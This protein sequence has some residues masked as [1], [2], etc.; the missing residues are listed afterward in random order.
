MVVVTASEWR[1]LLIASCAILLLASLP[2]LYAWSLADADHVFTGFVIGV[3]DGNSYLAKMRLGARGEW[4]FRL[5]YTPEEHKG[6]LL[7]TLYVLLG[8]VATFFRLPLVL[9]Y[10]LA[11]LLFGLFLLV[12]AYRLLAY[13]SR[14]VS[15]RRLAWLLIAI[16]S[17]LGWLLAILGASH[18]FG[19]L[20]L[21]FW[22]PEAYVFLVVYHLPHVALAEALL[23]LSIL[24]TL[25]TLEGRGVRWCVGGSLAA[26]FTASIVPFYA[27]V[28][29]AV[30]GSYL[31]A[32]LIRRRHMPWQETGQVAAV[33]LGALPPVAYNFWLLATSPAFSIWAQQLR[34]P[35]PHPLHYFLGFVLLLVPA[36]AGAILAI[37]QSEEKWLL[38][39]GWALVVPL[40][41]YF[42]FNLQRRMIVLIQVP[43]ALLAARGLM[44][45]LEKHA[46]KWKHLSIV[47][48][49][50]VVSFS[51]LL[52]ILGNLALVARQE[53]PIYR[54]GDEIAALR[55]LD[56]HATQGDT[57][58]SSFKVG[59]VI[60]AQTD[61][62]VFAGH[63]I[64]TLTGD[65][66]QNTIRQF[67]AAS[68]D[69]DWRRTLMAEF[70]LEYVFWG[71]IEQSIGDWDPRTAPYLVPICSGPGYTVFRV[72][73]DEAGP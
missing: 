13:F 2:T 10:H 31:L 60:P 50:V 54:P 33:G 5:V 70:D 8:K 42:P 48:Y 12:T 58:F 18:W 56:A 51:N 44:V 22:V 59:N 9:I 69:D 72:A 7:Y 38:P 52:L 14:S 64:E 29:A 32:L 21:E 67:F 47:A 71:P 19:D 24:W 1:W 27:G 3:E 16:G 17:G 37:Q 49:V 62:R 40:L 35:S 43:L 61:L 46:V 36:G 6:A 23:L 53:T 26:F 68:V 57:V 28:L 41:V 4:L 73:L 55:C 63:S 39:I 20:P 25:Y 65:E 34:M 66:K 11:R 30:L 45:W 15:V